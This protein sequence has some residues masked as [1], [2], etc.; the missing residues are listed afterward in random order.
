MCVYELCNH[1]LCKCI[2]VC[3]KGIAVVSAF[4]K[5]G[6]SKRLYVQP[7]LPGNFA[8]INIYICTYKSICRAHK[9]T[10]SYIGMIF[11]MKLAVKMCINAYTSTYTLEYM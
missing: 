7:A 8:I 5:N 6:D 2:K 4:A 11:D 3:K 10:T 9:L 1:Y